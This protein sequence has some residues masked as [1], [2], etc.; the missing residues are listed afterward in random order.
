MKAKI[1]LFFFC[2]SGLFMAS[3][4]AQ[5]GEPTK[6]PIL[7]IET[8]MHGTTLRRIGIDSQNRFL[9]TA[10]DDKTCRVWDLHT[11]RLIRTFR[12]PIDSF[13][14]GKI[15]SVAISPDGKHVACGGWTG[16]D[17]E[18]INYVYVFERETGKLFKRVSIESTGV[19]NHLTYSKDGRY[20]SAHLSRNGIRVFNAF[21]KYSLAFKDLDYGDY[22]LGGD[23]YG[24]SLLATAS[25]DG[26]VRLYNVSPTGIKLNSK[27]GAVG[28]RQPFGVSFHPNGKKL[29]ISFND[30]SKIDVYN[31]SS[32]GLQYA[33]SPD[34]SGVD[35]VLVG[36]TWSSDGRYLYAGG[37]FQKSINGTWTRIIRKWANEGQGAYVELPACYDMIMH[38]LSLKNGGIAFGAADPVFGAF[39]NS[40]K[41]ILF[42]TSSISDFRSNLKNFQVSDDGSIVK[43]SYDL[44]GKSPAKFS[45]IERI[46]TN[47][48]KEDYSLKSAI[49]NTLNITNWEHNRNPSLNGSPIELQKY[50]MARSLAIHPNGQYFAL[51]SDWHVRYYDK[52]GTLIWEKS[53][54]ST[55]WLINMSG[56]GKFVIAGF[57]DGTIRWLRA[58]DGQEVLALF[59]HNDK[60][61]WVIWTQSGYY[62]AGPGADEFIGWH[63]NNGKDFAADFF[64]I[65]KFRGTYYRP[66]VI[67]KVLETQEEN[68][69][70]TKANEESGKK[71]Q[72]V[73][74]QEMLPPVV[75]I[76]SP[77]DGAETNQN[78]IKVKYS[79]RSPSGEAIT[80]I[81]ILVDGRPISTQRGLTIVAKNQS[82]EEVR[83]AIVDLPGKNCEIS[84]IAENKYSSSEPAILRIT[85]KGKLQ[86][87]EFIIKP[88]LYV[89]SIGISQYKDARLKLGLAS[90]DARDFAGALL[91]QKGS[92]Y[93]DV[94]TKILTDAEATK[95]NILDALEWIQ[96]E[97]TSKDVAMIF[98]AGHGVNDSAGIY[99]YL[100]VGV[101]TEKLKRSGVPFTD[102]KNTITAIAGKA[103]FFVDTCHS[104]NV[105]GNRRAVADISGVVNEL[106][107]AE[108]GVVVFAS[109]TGNQF[110]LEDPRW[111]NGAFT[112]ALIEGLNGKA[113]YS[114]KGKIT[115]NMLDLYI[116]ERVK[117]LTKGQ[118]TPT[119]TKPSTI[120]DYPIATKK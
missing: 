45:V 62:D 109:S 13:N 55:T 84:I 98:L 78:S 4:S 75:Y 6:N 16:Y 119:T 116:S 18:S 41:K 40:D 73:S 117:E 103:L 33:Y 42:K 114:G 61:R 30:T 31:V 82:G 92:L 10:S 95:D 52:N 63:I 25:Y 113:D 53:S 23:F 90:K 67:A 120:P 43:F 12:P 112:K 88:K 65:S 87:E 21:Y 76:L 47:P 39:N 77:Q 50:E 5:A 38:M 74:L 1:L 83:E 80:G 28:G 54:P 46:L 72:Q 60:K 3:Y 86:N 34:T 24:S 15:Y 97:T 11:G 89:L 110:S 118:Q 115:I 17:W 57:G 108:N 58:T 91:K 36:V 44:Y 48:A 79:V 100:P 22:T 66:D 35:D 105:M 32:S 96:K 68:I 85:W 81:K 104:G 7:K 70:L 64:P 49:T 2:L 51:G 27:I 102:I 19:I 107:S 94:V 37:G 69:A 9:A 29:A 111:G 59:V 20:L 8:G 93:R 106:A 71:E 56:N 14:E 101:D 99:Y 26:Y